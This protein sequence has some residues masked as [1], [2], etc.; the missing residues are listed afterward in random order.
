MR[1]LLLAFLLMPSIAIATPTIRPGELPYTSP[2]S[3]E[4]VTF[5]VGEF[6]RYE[7]KA[8]GLKVMDTSLGV[9]GIEEVNGRKCYVLTGHGESSGLA[10]VFQKVFVGLKTYVDVRTHQLV[11]TEVWGQFGE[12]GGFN[13]V[14]DIDQ[15]ACTAEVTG[16]SY[17]DDENQE[18]LYTETASYD[19]GA[20]DLLLHLM[21]M[22]DLKCPEGTEI[23]LRFF[24]GNSGETW[25]LVVDDTTKVRTPVGRAET[26][27]LV[28][29]DFIQYITTD[30]R[31]LPMRYKL[32]RG[33]VG[34]TFNLVEY[35]PG[36]IEGTSAQHRPQ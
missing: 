14:A 36:S 28:I 2:C 1:T 29:D 20:P 23:P 5:R 31:R 32:K 34:V 26:V 24:D 30:D 3:D 21:R 19:S 22:R 13:V 17:D 9:S 33:M 8:L 4:P 27:R 25:P 35:R 7:A 16:G 10:Q 6:M 12:A 18:K 15:A 11:R